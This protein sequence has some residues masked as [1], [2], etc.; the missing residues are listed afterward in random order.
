MGKGAVGC[1]MGSMSQREVGG[2][3]EECYLPPQGSCP[4]QCHHHRG[5]TGGSNSWWGSHS[6]PF[7]PHLPHFLLASLCQ[8]PAASPSQSPDTASFLVRS[9]P[10]LYSFSRRC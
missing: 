1:P 2:G 8:A 3:V 5:K 10:W 9:R 6:H 4:S 7:L